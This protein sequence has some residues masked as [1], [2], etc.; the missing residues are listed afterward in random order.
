MKAF[1]RASYRDFEVRGYGL[2][3]HMGS[4]LIYNTKYDDDDGEKA[5]IIR[6]EEK[7]MD[8]IIENA[9]RRDK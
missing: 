8:I 9:I 3:K 7:D 1:D 5:K 2:V 6:V 4:C